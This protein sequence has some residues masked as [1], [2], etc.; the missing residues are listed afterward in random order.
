MGS[1]ASVSTLLNAFH[2]KANSQTEESNRVYQLRKDLIANPEVRLAFANYVRDKGIYNDMVRELI[3]NMD[4]VYLCNIVVED[5]WDD[6]NDY[7]I[8]IVHFMDSFSKS[9]VYDHYYRMSVQVVEAPILTRNCTMEN[10]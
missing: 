5:L 7:A 3:L 4:E 9:M 1:S 8:I 10:L 2:E 6:D